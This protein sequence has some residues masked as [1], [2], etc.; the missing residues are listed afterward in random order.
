MMIVSPIF[1]DLVIPHVIHAR[2]RCK[3]NV[4]HAQICWFSEGHMTVLKVIE[5]DQKEQ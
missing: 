1:S 3:T 2:A 5:S 4:C